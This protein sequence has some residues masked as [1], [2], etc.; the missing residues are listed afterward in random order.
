MSNATRRRVQRRQQEQERAAV[1]EQLDEL[2]PQQQ[3]VETARMSVTNAENKLNLLARCS[4]VLQGSNAE[5]APA[6]MQD[7]IF[8]DAEGAEGEKT[9][10]LCR[11]IRDALNESRIGFAQAILNYIDEIDVLMNTPAPTLVAPSTE[12]VVVVGESKA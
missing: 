9:R 11:D 5:Q 6:E 3:R 1:R 8:Y 4:E 12:D 7:P 2:S 10:Q